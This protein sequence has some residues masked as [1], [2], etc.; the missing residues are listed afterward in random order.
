[1]L[2]SEPDGLKSQAWSSGMSE[3]KETSKVIKSF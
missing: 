1:M 2:D 3:V